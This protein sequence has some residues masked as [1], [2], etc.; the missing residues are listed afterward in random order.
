MQPKKA[1]RE[2]GT[3]RDMW[4]RK[5]DETRCLLTFDTT[6]SKLAM[7]AAIITHLFVA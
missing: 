1:N 2:V 4:C 3:Y 6:D 5:K 7:P